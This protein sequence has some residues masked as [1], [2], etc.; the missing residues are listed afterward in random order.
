LPARDA[1]CK[2]AR[3]CRWA[4]ELNPAITDS[5]PG[6]FDLETFTTL[7][8]GDITLPEQWRML[9]AFEAA[10]GVIMFGWTTALIVA[11]VQRMYV[12]HSPE[13]TAD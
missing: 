4:T 5:N 9:G 10:T 1:R 6:L 2:D 8:Y 12:R 3:I 11:V 7:G 13:E